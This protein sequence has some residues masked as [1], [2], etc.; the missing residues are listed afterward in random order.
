MTTLKNFKKLLPQ[1]LKNYYHFIKAHYYA[2]IYQYPARNLK[3]V[4]ITGTD[5]KT[6][7]TSLLHHILSAS[8]TEKTGL[9]TSIE[10]KFGNK[11]IPSGL[12]VTSPDPGD[13]QKTLK[14][15]MNEDIKY[16]A[17]ETTS[18]GLD[19]HRVAGVKYV[20]AIFTNVTR[21]HLDYHKTYRNYLKTKS[22]L[23]NK[24]QEKGFVILNK[25]DTSYK[26]L[27]NKAQRLKKKIITYSLK[28][29][30][31]DFYVNDINS[32]SHEFKINHRN[33][34]YK[35]KIPLPGNYNISN[36]IAALAATVQMGVPIQ[37][38]VKSLSTF[39]TL[40]GRWNLIQE[41]P[42]KVIIDF[43]HTPNAL[44][45]A[46]ITAKKQS[47]NR[48]IVVFGCAG[49]R[50]FYKRAEMG[51]IAGEKANIT[52]ITAEDPRSEDVNEIN[53]QIEQGI[54]ENKDTPEYL[55][56]ADREK[57]IKKALSLAK[58]GDLILI[59][60]K[61]HE[62]SMNLD[63]KKEIPWNDHEIVKKALQQQK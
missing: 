25:D 26:F 29:S 52:I 17:L 10:I 4:G 36:A 23:I 62:R 43:A 48:V 45:K 59:T 27:N 6:T 20:G 42:F 53:K 14:T 47:K 7:T 16:V 32:R 49:E 35:C 33:K 54:L 3:I 41:Q 24:V 38:G 51:K 30:T 44:E 31:A 15:M 22:K 57:A 5:G 28:D 21:E 13:L 58:K 9:I 60:G 19:Q 12:H 8:Q 34:S 2:T 11:I 61:G 63:G 50:D 55:I 18:H 39:K 46:L 37:K 40:K 1:T 56:I